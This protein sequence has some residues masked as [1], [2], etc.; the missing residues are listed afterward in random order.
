MLVSGS[1]R[2]KSPFSRLLAEGDLKSGH[3]R[4]QADRKAS[5]GVMIG[6]SET[7]FGGEGSRTPPKDSEIGMDFNTIDNSDA[8]PTIQHQLTEQWRQQRQ[9]IPEFRRPISFMRPLPIFDHID[10]PSIVLPGATMP[11]WSPTSSVPAS[12]FPCSC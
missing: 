2:T 12:G 3:G 8:S 9:V 1:V 6:Q 4:R 5:R 10:A 11:G 7:A